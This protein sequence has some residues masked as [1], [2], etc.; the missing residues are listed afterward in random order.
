[1]HDWRRKTKPLQECQHVAILATVDVAVKQILPDE[2]RAIK[3]QEFCPACS[4]V[5]D[6][7]LWPPLNGGWYLRLQERFAAGRQWYYRREGDR[8]I[9]GT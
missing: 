6:V 2:E 1:M 7:R 8:W 5:L 4:W 9:A 3:F